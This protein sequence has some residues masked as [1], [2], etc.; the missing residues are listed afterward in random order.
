M[1]QAEYY[2]KSLGLQAMILLM[3]I[4]FMILVVGLYF[5]WLIKDFVLILYLFGLSL[6]LFFSL[7]FIN[8]FQEVI[9]E[10]L[11]KK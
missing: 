4:D 5:L 10:W 1:K 11:K 8:K 3:I 6:I 7:Y 9:T 2:K